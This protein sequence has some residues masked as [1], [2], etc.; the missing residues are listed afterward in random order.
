MNKFYFFSYYKSRTCLLRIEK[1]VKITHNHI[2]HRLA[3]FYYY[4]LQVFFNLFM[5]KKVILILKISNILKII[6]LLLL[7]LSRFSHV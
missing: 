5:A 4:F 6:L 7:L 2:T 3:S 1:N